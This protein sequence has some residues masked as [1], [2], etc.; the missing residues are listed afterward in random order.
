MKETVMSQKKLG[1]LQAQVPIDGKEL[2][3]ER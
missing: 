3:A 2:L 1:K